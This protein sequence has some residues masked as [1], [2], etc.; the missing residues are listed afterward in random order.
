M[1]L[2][3]QLARRDLPELVVQP[4]H[5]PVERRAVAA[6]EL[7]QQ[8]RSARLRQDRDLARTGL[9]IGAVSGFSRRP[10]HLSLKDDLKPSI[11]ARE[12]H[13]DPDGDAPGSTAE[14]A[15]D[16]LVE[17]LDARDLRRFRGVHGLP[18]DQ[19][20]LLR[21]ACARGPLTAAD[22]ARD[23]RTDARYVREWLEQQ[24]VAGIVTAVLGGDEPVFFLP[25]GHDEVLAASRQPGLPRPA[26]AAHRRRGE[27]A[28][29]SRGGVPL[30]RRCSIRALR[31]RHARRARRA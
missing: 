23:D 31:Q 24:S 21:H 18:R 14:A 9:R 11:A 29:G 7:G 17:R 19:L 6:A 28:A 26:V 10:P 13:H 12:N 1:A 4:R 27:A 15:R 20:G 30:R 25:P 2:A 8:P 3:P 16:A 22:L 5:G